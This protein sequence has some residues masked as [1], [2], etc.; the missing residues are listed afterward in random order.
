LPCAAPTSRCYVNIPKGASTIIGRLMAAIAI[1]NMNARSVRRGM[2]L[3]PADKGRLEMIEK[4]ICY[5]DGKCYVEWWDEEM[6]NTH[7]NR[8]A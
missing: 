4:Y 2:K 8:S 3:T 6:R 1:I 5:D 7:R